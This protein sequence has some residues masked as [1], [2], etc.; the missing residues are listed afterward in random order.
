MKALIAIV[1]IVIICYTAHHV[2]PKKT[3]ESIIRHGR[4][5]TLFTIVAVALAMIAY[6]TPINP[7]FQP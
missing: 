1:V 2:L 3:L 6:F 5:I 7:Y 4:S